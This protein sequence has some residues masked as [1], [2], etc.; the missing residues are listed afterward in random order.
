VSSRWVAEVVF[1]DTF[2]AASRRVFLS[3]VVPDDTRASII[4][5]FSVR[6]FGKPG[7]IVAE[8]AENGSKVIVYSSE[9]LARKL[10]I[11]SRDEP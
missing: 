8:G 5:I 11:E 4:S 3:A 6:G 2:K 7:V 1:R 10:C 9:E